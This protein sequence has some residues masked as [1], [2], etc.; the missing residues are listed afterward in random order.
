MSSDLK[1]R[2]G[3][4][5]ALALAP[6]STAAPPKSSHNSRRPQGRTQARAR[7]PPGWG[8]WW[9][10]CLLPC[11]RPC[12]DRN[13]AP[14]R[15]LS[16]YTTIEDRPYNMVNTSSNGICTGI[17]IPLLRQLPYKTQSEMLKAVADS[18]PLIYK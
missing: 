12:V 18:I 14:S 16:L 3:G 1:H 2:R 7:G 13:L 5:P 9:P 11:V 6:A 10:P 4:N 15:P 8:C 17:V